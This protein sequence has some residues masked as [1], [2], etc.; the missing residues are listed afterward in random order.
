MI[1]FSHWYLASRE[2]ICLVFVSGV[3]A[4][5]TWLHGA[6]TCLAG[7]SGAMEEPAV[8]NWILG[9]K[10]FPVLAQYYQCAEQVFPFLERLQVLLLPAYWGLDGLMHSHLSSH[11][12]QGTLWFAH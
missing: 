6:D 7:Q 9:G 8:I 1:P 12:T 10:N 11:F 4:R 3:T 5:A 2:G